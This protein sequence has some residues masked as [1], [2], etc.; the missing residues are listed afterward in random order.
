MAHGALSCACLRWGNRSPVLTRICEIEFNLTVMK[1]N[2]IVAENYRRYQDSQQRNGCFC[3]NE[4]RMNR[5][6][7]S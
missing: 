4:L 1:I 3:E 2:F 7:S 5:E 6:Q